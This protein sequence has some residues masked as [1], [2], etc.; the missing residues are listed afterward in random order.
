M[1]AWLKSAATAVA[2]LAMGLLVLPGAV[3]AQDVQ[4]QPDAQ[5]Q[6]PSP[7]DHEELVRFTEAM[8]DVTEVQEELQQT[9]AGIENPEEASQVQQQAN[10]EMEEILDEH[11]LTA[12]RYSEVVTVLDMDPELNAEFQQ[13]LDEILEERGEELGPM[14]PN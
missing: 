10:L 11:D 9:L 1:N 14:G 2:L 8:L 12:Q 4:P 13:I 5:Q 6:P 3:Q 7:P